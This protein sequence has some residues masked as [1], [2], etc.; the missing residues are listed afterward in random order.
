M[1]KIETELPDALYRQLQALI[2]DGWYRDEGDLIREAVRRLLSTHQPELIEKQ[3][4]DDVE[5]GL[6]G[7]E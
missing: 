1:K 5:W 7:K 2:R 4:R 3:M 6:R